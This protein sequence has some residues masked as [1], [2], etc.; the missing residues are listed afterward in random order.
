MNCATIENSNTSNEIFAPDFNCFCFLSFIYTIK[1]YVFLIMRFNNFIKPAFWSTHFRRG[2]IPEFNLYLAN[3]KRFLVLLF[4]FFV[5]IKRF[6]MLLKRFLVR[7]TQFLVWLSY[8]FV[9]LERFFMQLTHFLKLFSLIYV[10]RNIC[11]LQ[12]CQPQRSI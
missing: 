6:L 4:H 1:G 12:F 7:L 2:H 10:L 5:Q 8:F 11:L 3:L 9:Q